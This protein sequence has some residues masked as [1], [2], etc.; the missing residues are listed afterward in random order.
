M[1]TEDHVPANHGEIGPLLLS[2]NG[3]EAARV[4][5]A[6]ATLAKNDVKK[7]GH[8]LDRARED[9]RDVLWW[10]DIQDEDDRRKRQL[11]GLGLQDRLAIL[12]LSADWTAVVSRGDRKHAA[13]L[14][15]RCD[16]PDAEV[17]RVLATH[18]SPAGNQPRSA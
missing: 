5:K 2:Y 6:I 17:E 9:Y 7:A 13:A 12:K 4:R 16:L 14:L 8:Y 10:A 15:K 11:A 3:P 18:F 1:A